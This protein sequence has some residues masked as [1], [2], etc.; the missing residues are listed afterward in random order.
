MHLFQH[1]LETRT[2]IHRDLVCLADR[3]FRPGRTIFSEIIKSLNE[4]AVF[5]A[6]LSRNYCNSDYCKLE[7]EQACLQRKPI[8]LMFIEK[9]EEERMNPVIRAIFRKYTRVKFI[10]EDGHYRL[11]PDW[12]NVCDSIM[13]LI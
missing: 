8:I 6:V 13:Q 12:E 5:I 2:G 7:I 9:V 4:S 3:H 1:G 10:L 11:Q